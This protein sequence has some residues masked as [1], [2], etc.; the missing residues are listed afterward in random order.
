[1]TWAMAVC[2]LMGFMYVNASHD[3]RDKADTLVVLLTGEKPAT[4][5]FM[6]TENE[7]RRRRISQRQQMRAGKVFFLIGFAF[8][9]TIVILEKI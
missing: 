3:N 9:A 4:V 6:T 7:I 8:M 1:M 5:G 2:F